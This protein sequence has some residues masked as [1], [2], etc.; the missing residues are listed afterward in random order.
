MRE[1]KQKSQPENWQQNQDGDSM[2]NEPKESCKLLLNCSVEQY[3][4]DP[5]VIPS[6]SASIA[7]TLISKSPLH[8]FTEHPRLGGKKRPET[9]ETDKGSLIHALVLG[10][11]KDTVVLPYQNWQT[12]A[13]R[14]DREA[15]RLAGKIP[16]LEKDYVEAVEIANQ[17]NWR[18]I[19]DFGIELSGLSEQPI[20][21]IE[22][23]DE[24][25]EVQ[26]RACYD[27]L[28]LQQAHAF[29]LKTTSVS[30]HPNALAAHM[31]RYGSHIQEAAYLSALNKLLPEREGKARFT[32]L[33]C[34]VEPPYAVVPAQLNG[35]MK[36]LAQ[37]QWRR[38][39]NIWAE[40]LR[41]NNWPSYTD[42]AVNVNAPVWA[43]TQEA[44]FGEIDVEF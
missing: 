21:W 38:A 22:L 29:D 32:F 24:G 2:I 25:E 3:H 9:K 28:I 40:C 37:R 13:A 10:K 44:E 34:E 15:A 5:C 4:A 11:G 33:F 1:V 14:E 16:T 39:V 26:C 23:S 36:L 6:L 17:I 42:K 41:T 12:K 7:H 18:L 8:A 43:L 19:Y 31:I 27:H 35:S 20:T 30:A